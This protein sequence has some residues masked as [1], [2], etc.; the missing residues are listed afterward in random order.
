MAAADTGKKDKKCRVCTD[1]RSWSKAQIKQEVGE[2]THCLTLH[3]TIQGTCSRLQRLEDKAC[4]PDGLELGRCS[5]M[6]LHSIAAYY[7][8]IP[9]TQQQSD[10]KQFLNLFSK[11]Y[12]CEECAEHMRRR[13]VV[14]LLYDDSTYMFHALHHFS[15]RCLLKGVCVQSLYVNVIIKR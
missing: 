12:P 4:P 3:C 5:W 1:F 8:D 9:S 15:K 13:L 11:I 7:P 2:R 10:M 6:F 14:N